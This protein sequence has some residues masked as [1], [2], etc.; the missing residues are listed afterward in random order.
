M[1]VNIE[2]MELWIG[3]DKR[4]DYPKQFVL[5]VLCEIANGEY[6][7]EQLKSDVLDMREENENV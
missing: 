1:R 5:E 7:P 3:T 2:D 4:G 6:E